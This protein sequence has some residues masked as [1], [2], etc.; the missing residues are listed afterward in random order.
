MAYRILIAEDHKEISDV[1]KQY[2]LKEGY[3]V[4]VVGSGIEALSTM[5][6]SQFHLLILD[7]MMPGVDGMEV[8]KTLRTYSDIPIIMLT[9]KVQESDRISGFDSGAD[10]YVTKP[11]SPKELLGRVKALLK[12]SYKETKSSLLIFGNLQL[13]LD[14]MKVLKNDEWIELTSAECHLLKVFMT[15]PRRILSREELMVYAFGTE[16]DGFDRNMDSY[17]KR[18]RQKI[19]VDPKRPVLIQ[20]KYGAGYVFGGDSHEY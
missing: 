13:D 17:I 11:F 5:S 19:E 3:E 8:L 14:A 1:V 20:T 2:L 7:I 18:L 6:Q 10:D 15:Y 12:R 16:Y 9:A 4:V